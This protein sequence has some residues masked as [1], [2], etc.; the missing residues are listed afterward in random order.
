MV[1]G[2]CWLR[3]DDWERCKQR[4]A[5]T[6]EVNGNSAGDANQGRLRVVADS[7]Q[8]TLHAY[9]QG[10]RDGGGVAAGIGS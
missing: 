1:D 9:L 2:A 7:V 10:L 3:V 8:R 4:V 5:R 6:V